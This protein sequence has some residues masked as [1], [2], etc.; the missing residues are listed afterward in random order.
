MA[1]CP[2]YYELEEKFLC[3]A[4]IKAAATNYEVLP[5][6]SDDDLDCSNDNE[7]DKSHADDS[8]EEAEDAPQQNYATLANGKRKQGNKT[9]AKQKA[10][11]KKTALKAK[12]QQG[13]DALEESLAKLINATIKKKKDEEKQHK[14]SGAEIA[15]L[16]SNFKITADALGGRVAA[17]A[18]FSKFKRF[19]TREEK[20]ELEELQNTSEDSDS[21]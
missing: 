9:P 6:D 1:Q 19:L 12:A 20:R 10:S 11:A 18:S 2:F 5:S 16:A 4:G 3:R 13:G 21:V 7:N 15:A 8:S 17:A 14:E